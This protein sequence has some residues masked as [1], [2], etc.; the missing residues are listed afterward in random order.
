METRSKSKRN[1]RG[2]RDRER[3]LPKSGSCTRSARRSI[4]ASGSAIRSASF[5]RALGRGLGDQIVSTDC[6]GCVERP[7]GA[8]VRPRLAQVLYLRHGAVAAG[9][10]LPDGDSDHRRASL[11]LFTAVGRRLWCGYTAPQTVYTEIF[12]D[13]A[14]DRGRS[15]KRMRARQGSDVGPQA[16]EGAKHAA[17]VAS[18]CGPGSP[19]S[20]TSRRSAAR[21]RRALRRQR[22]SLFWILFYGFATYGNAG[23]LREQVCI[24][25]CPRAFPERDVRSDTLIVTYDRSAD[26]TRRRQQGID[27]RRTELGDCVLAAVRAGVPD[28]HRYSTA[29]STSA[30][31]APPASMP[32]TT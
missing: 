30:S 4:R 1:R 24:Y 21:S 29:C 12:M 13:R 26:A 7:P 16:A 17:W 25:M 8:A 2:A 14:P 3:A 9:H 19:S 15:A 18:L 31:A 11:F 10:H 23:W 20:A 6:R 32:A 5:R 27:A 28:R 22:W